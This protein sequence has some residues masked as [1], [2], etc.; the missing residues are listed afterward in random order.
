VEEGRSPASGEDDEDASGRH[1]PGC[2][3]G[4]HMRW[5]ASGSGGAAAAGARGMSQE[6][7]WT[8]VV[9][10]ESSVPRERGGAGCMGGFFC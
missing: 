2:G 8:H 4:Q 6:R 10:S 3:G 1:W 9:I 5:L 7:R